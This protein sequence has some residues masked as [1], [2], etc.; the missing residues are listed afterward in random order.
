[1]IESKPTE[2]SIAAT[3]A[4]GLAGLV[5][6]S[7]MPPLTIVCGWVAQVF[8]NYDISVVKLFAHVP[9]AAVSGVVFNWSAAVLMAA[10]MVAVVIYEA[11]HQKKV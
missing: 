2:P 8:T 4:V 3:M 7:I 5:V 6:S 1:M 11:H 10:G 9:G